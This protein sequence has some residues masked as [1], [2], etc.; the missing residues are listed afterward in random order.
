MWGVLGSTAALAGAAAAIRS[1]SLPTAA[2]KCPV[3]Y[4]LTRNDS[5]PNGACSS[6]LQVIGDSPEV[7]HESAITPTGIA[8]DPEHNIF[9]TYAR[10]MDTK[11]N[12][13]TKATSFTEE[14][15]WPSEQ[16]QNCAEGQNA[17]TCFVNVQNVVLDSVGGWWVIDSG[18]PNGAS[19]PV[20]D[21]PKVINFNYTTGEVIRT[22]IYPEDQWLAKLQLNDIRINNTLGTSGYAFITEDTQYGSISTLDLGTGEFIRHLYNTTFTRPDER[23]TSMYNGEPIRNWNG[24]KPSYMNSGTNGIALASG[25]VYWGV[26]SSHRWY[27]VSQEALVS[28]LTDDELSAKVRIPGNIPSEQAGFTADDRG[29]VYT[30]ASEQNAIL[31]VDTLE[32]EVTDPVTAVPADGSG[33]VPAENLV[34]RTLLRSGLVQAAD[35]A[36]ILDGWLYFST[37]QQGLAPLRQYKNVDRRRGPFRSYRYWIG[38]GPAV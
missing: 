7:I 35:T 26:K 20:P 22:Y 27:F 2:P 11:N 24:T 3:P 14:I 15:P 8:V 30:M 28:G 36:C 29:R 32:S 33:V 37:N 10:N 9:F 21:G 31:Y 6:D 25:N 18:V 17:S 1:A 16:W 34:H 19:M 12:T 38:R 13:M 5:D 4:S 23:F